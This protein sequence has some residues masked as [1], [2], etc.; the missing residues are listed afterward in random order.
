MQSPEIENHYQQKCS[1]LLKRFPLSKMLALFFLVLSLTASVFCKTK[2]VRFEDQT[3]SLFISPEKKLFISGPWSEDPSY[4]DEHVEDAWAS[5]NLFQIVIV[6]QKNE[7]IDWVA[8]KR[9]TGE[10][11]AGGVLQPL[12]AED[13]LVSYSAIQFLQPKLNMKIVFDDGRFLVYEIDAH[14]I[15]KIVRKGKIPHFSEGK[16]P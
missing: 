8:L 11:M 16:P 5:A 10:K 4:L 7:E 14:G 6:I 2:E 12:L 13:G 1:L 15:K 9:E 3:Y